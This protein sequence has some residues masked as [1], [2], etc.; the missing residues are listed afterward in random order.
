MERIRR[1]GETCRLLL[2]ISCGEVYVWDRFSG[3]PT[4][5]FTDRKKTAGVL[6]DRFPCH[7]RRTLFRGPFSVGVLSPLS[8][9]GVD[10]QDSRACGAIE[11]STF[12]K[13]CS[14]AI[15]SFFRSKL[16]FSAVFLFFSSFLSFCW[17]VCPFFSCVDMC[18]FCV[19]RKPRVLGERK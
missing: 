14:T 16:F 3:V 5:K 10:V 18:T 19:D 1:D 7:V 11:Q 6:F 8:M 4:V 12:T 2:F 13:F 9:R 15:S 17:R